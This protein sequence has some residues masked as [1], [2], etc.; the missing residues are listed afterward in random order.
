MDFLF[1]IGGFALKVMAIAMAFA[2]VMTLLIAQIRRK[3]SSPFGQMNVVSLN[4]HF[5]QMRNNIRKALMSKKDYKAAIKQEKKA[6]QPNT[7]AK[8]VFVLD[9]EGDIAA[10]AVTD[11]REQ[12]TALITIVN[13]EDEVVIRLESAGG[14]VTHYGLAASQLARLRDA[15]IP[16]TACVDKVAASGGYLMAAVANQILAAP[17]AVVGSIGVLAMIPNFHRLLKKLDVDFYEMTAG[18]YKTTI[19]PVGEVTEKGKAKFKEELEE[20]HQL[21]KAYIHKYRGQIDLGKVATGEHWFGTNAI[22][23]ALVDRLIT[24]DDYLLGL[25]QTADI[26]RVDYQA[27]K[28]VKEKVANMFAE[29]SDK[30]LL[31][32][33]QRLVMGRGFKA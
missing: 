32:W 6:K 19:T 8:R 27:P 29:A 3:T 21:F 14:M 15:G 16:L 30:V 20:V 13:Q 11:L 26:Y 22:D 31:R 23:L 7:P 4:S 9:F 33:F 5:K 1:D 2:I 25:S 17:F 10:T 12:V 28:T 24:S 18:E